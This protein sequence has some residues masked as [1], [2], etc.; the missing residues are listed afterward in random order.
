MG[1]SHDLQPK[2]VF[3][4]ADCADQ[5]PHD[6]HLERY[7]LTST[8]QHHSPCLAVDRRPSGYIKY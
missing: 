1:I 3:R 5:P 4:P 8:A 7:E 2:I 6:R